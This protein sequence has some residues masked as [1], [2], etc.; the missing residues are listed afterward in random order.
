MYVMCVC[1]VSSS[2]DYKLDLLSAA[3]KTIKEVGLLHIRMS[4]HPE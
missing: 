4:H 1:V 2:I 3:A